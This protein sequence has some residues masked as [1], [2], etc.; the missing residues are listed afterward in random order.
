MHGPQHLSIVNLRLFPCE[1]L[2]QDDMWCGQSHFRI[3]SLIE[4][5][6]NNQKI[7]NNNSTIADLQ[8]KNVAKTIMFDLL[9]LIRKLL[10]QIIIG[11]RIIRWFGLMDELRYFHIGSTQQTDAVLS[12]RHLL[13]VHSTVIRVVNQSE[14]ISKILKPVLAIAHLHR[15]KI[16][17][18]HRRLV[19][20]P[21]DTPGSSRANILAQ[22]PV[23]KA[24]VGF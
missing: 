1:R 10:S 20:K 5:L 9:D 18:V 17:L 22:V 11:V 2:V 21:R 4:L 24:W 12:Q 19:V 6:A 15:V 13:A 14:S 3:L 7:K 8:Q 23:P 16:A